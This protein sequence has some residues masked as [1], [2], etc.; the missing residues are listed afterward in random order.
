M[1]RD[2]GNPC[3][4]RGLEV[5]EEQVCVK[6]CSG[7]E[8]GAAFS[9]WIRERDLD[10]AEKLAKSGR[11]C[12]VQFQSSFKQEKPAGDGVVCLE[13]ALPGACFICRK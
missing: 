13:G 3:G 10:K 12:Y 7:D 9:N 8:G 4:T 5:C 1:L 2:A 11:Q 6:C